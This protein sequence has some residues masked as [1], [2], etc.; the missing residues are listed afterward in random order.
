M[1]IEFEILG[2]GIGRRRVFDEEGDTV[3]EEHHEKERFPLVVVVNDTVEEK[4]DMVCD[5]VLEDGGA[6]SGRRRR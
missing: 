3:A 4:L 6:R 2:G 5:V 1:G